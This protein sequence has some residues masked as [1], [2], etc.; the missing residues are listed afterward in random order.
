[1]KQIYNTFIAINIRE[2]SELAVFQDFPSPLLS[3]YHG[4]AKLTGV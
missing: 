2:K 4:P 3:R 1:M